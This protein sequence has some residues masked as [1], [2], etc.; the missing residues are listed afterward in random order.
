[1]RIGVVTGI[2]GSLFAESHFWWHKNAKGDRKGSAEGMRL[3]RVIN[4]FS[5][6]RALI[7]TRDKGEKPKEML[8]DDGSA[9][10]FRV[11]ASEVDRYGAPDGL[12]VQN[13]ERLVNKQTVTVPNHSRLA[14]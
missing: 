8:R 6:M 14:S 12:T 5:R 11:P 2:F 7:W 13:L 10:S 4:V 1:M 9:Y 3:G